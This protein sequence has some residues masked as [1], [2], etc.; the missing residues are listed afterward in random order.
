MGRHKIRLAVAA[1]AAVAASGVIVTS[2]TAQAADTTVIEDVT[3]D[4]Y[5][6][7]VGSSGDPYPPPVISAGPPTFATGVDFTIGHPTSVNQGAAFNI[8]VDIAGIPGSF[9]N[10]NAADNDLWTTLSSTNTTTASDEIFTHPGVTGVPFEPVVYPTATHTLTVGA[11][12]TGTVDVTVDTWHINNF[13]AGIH[14]ICSA[15]S[16]VTVSI[17]INVEPTA[18]TTADAGTPATTEADAGTPATT[19][20]GGGE[21]AATGFDSTALIAA[22]LILGAIGLIVLGPGMRRRRGV[23][24]SAVD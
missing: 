6:G 10:I 11:A 17:P 14:V 3:C 23:G 15:D 16:P 21:L 19:E 7:A 2:G 18:T 9:V 8:S 22:G 24:A 5:G 12:A 4:A 20:A 1:A 13:A